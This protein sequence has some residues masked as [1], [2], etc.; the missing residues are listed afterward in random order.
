LHLIIDSS[1]NARCIYDETIPLQHLGRIKIRRGS[2]VEPVPSGQWIADMK[3][4]DGPVLGPF[5]MRSQALAAERR[6]LEKYWLPQD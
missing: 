5:S 1:G 3:P 6:W 4:V 2:H